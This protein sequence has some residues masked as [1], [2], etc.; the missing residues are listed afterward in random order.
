MTEVQ[1]NVLLSTK[2]FQI[3]PKAV[4]TRTYKGS[5]IVQVIFKN[6]LNFFAFIF[7]HSKKKLM[8]L[9]QKLFRIN[10]NN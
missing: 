3:H 5:L 4:R 6:N 7:P 2:F 9:S 1:R 10:L 8:Q